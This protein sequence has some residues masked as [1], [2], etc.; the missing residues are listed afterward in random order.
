MCSPQT[1]HTPVTVWATAWTSAL[2]WHTM[3]C[4]G[5]AYFIT[6]LSTGCRETSAVASGAHPPPPSLL[7][8]FVALTFSSLPMQCFTLSSPALFPRL[9]QN[10]CCAK[11][12]PAVRPLEPDG[13]GYDQHRA[14]PASPHRD[15]PGSFPLPKPCHANPRLLLCFL[16]SN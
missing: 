12:C 5:T 7:T 3:S 14:D 8:L 16:I 2:T 11:P 10:E 13:T 15:F 1:A 4:R 6:V 9:P